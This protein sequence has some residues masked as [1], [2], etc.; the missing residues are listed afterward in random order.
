ME[1]AVEV[2]K[3]AQKNIKRKKTC[4]HR[5]HLLFRNYRRPLPLHPTNCWK[6]WG[7]TFLQQLPL[8]L[9]QPCHPQRSLPSWTRRSMISTFVYFIYATW[10]CS[11]PCPTWNGTSNVPSPESVECSRTET[12]KTVTWVHDIYRRLNGTFICECNN[13][14]SLKVSNSPQNPGR[15]FFVWR[16]KGGCRFFQWADVGFTKKTNNYKNCSK[17]MAGFKTFY[18]TVNRTF[19]QL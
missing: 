17:N 8:L 4:R 2:K 3:K 13:Q 10:N 7:S 18:L 16:N 15:P 1:T 14:A 9:I 11:K 5:R 6:K 12:S 19:F